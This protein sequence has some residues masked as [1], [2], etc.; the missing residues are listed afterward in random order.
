VG[1][2]VLATVVAAVAWAAG[3]AST[4]RRDPMSYFDRGY[5]A[6]ERGQ[7]QAASDDFTQY[8]RMDPSSAHRSE[9]YYYRGLAEVRLGRRSEA[10]QD[11]YRAVGAAAD[12]KIATYARVALGNLYYEDGD[13]G[14]AL[15]TYGP[16]IRQGGDDVPMEKVLLRM[17]VS[18]QRTGRWSTADAYLARVIRDYGRTPEATEAR[19]RYRAKAFTVQTGAY[20][21]VATARSE[22]ERL[23][24]VG[25]AANVGRTISSGRSLHTVRVGAARTYTE[26]DALASRLHA[27]GF[28]TQIVP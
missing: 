14:R 26:A 1:R 12:P 8:L 7:W 19:R 27:A 23:R 9:V 11:F 4:A 10:K 24:R 20:G 3:C 21:S 22:A 25:F 5:A 6:F 13:D 18:L 17:A 16:V 2:V 28:S 15:A